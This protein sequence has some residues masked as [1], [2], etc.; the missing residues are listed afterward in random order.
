M[1]GSVQ[2]LKKWPKPILT[3]DGTP[4]RRPQAEKKT[5]PKAEKKA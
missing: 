4:K 3:A 5:E 1:T 2:R